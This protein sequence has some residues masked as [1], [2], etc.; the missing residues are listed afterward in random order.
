MKLKQ[1]TKK[2]TISLI[3]AGLAILMVAAAIWTVVSSVIGGVTGSSSAA[4]PPVLMYQGDF[5]VLTN[6]E[7]KTPPT[8]LVIEA[9]AVGNQQSLP[10]RNGTCN[11]G[12]GTVQFRM[13]DV[14]QGYCA[15]ADGKWFYCRKV[16]EEGESSEDASV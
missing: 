14:G 4:Y 5:Y 8:G 10:P 13:N 2:R 7:A 11:F 12:S 16:G 6:E 9:K 3:S 1:S 15:D